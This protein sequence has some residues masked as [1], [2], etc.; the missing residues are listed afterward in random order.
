MLIK[1]VT[2]TFDVPHE[3]GETFTL[4][5]LSYVEAER[6]Q[7]VRQTKVLRTVK[8]MGADVLKALQDTSTEAQQGPAS[9]R[10]DV[11]ETLVAGIVGWSYD[12]PVSRENVELLDEQTARWAFER[13]IELTEGDNAEDA[14]KKG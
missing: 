2:K 8:E 3:K 1:S 6:A 12:E 7:E 13:I 5:K 4:R 14:R 11:T 10:Y 9:A